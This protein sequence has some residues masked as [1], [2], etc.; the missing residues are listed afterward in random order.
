MAEEPGKEAP[1]PEHRPDR[2]G[3]AMFWILGMGMATIWI[4][5]PLFLIIGFGFAGH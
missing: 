4:W 3:I 5:Y 2:V 1:E